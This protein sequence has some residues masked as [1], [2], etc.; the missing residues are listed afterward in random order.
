[1]NK[2]LVGIVC[3]LMILPVI[4]TTATA[5]IILPL[6]LDVMGGNGVNIVIQNNEEED[7]TNVECSAC[8][9]GGVFGLIDES[10]YEQ[11]PVLEGQ[12]TISIN[13]PVFG[14]GIVAVVGF[15]GA[16]GFERIIYQRHCLVL[17]SFVV[18]LGAV[19]LDT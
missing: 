19:I 11:I 4:T 12:D 5:D 6:Q 17:G 8:I 15:Y 2:K 1:M 16:D 18:A 7:F 13:I 9:I 14:L 10:K 3:M